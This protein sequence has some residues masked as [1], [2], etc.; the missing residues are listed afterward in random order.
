[1][2]EQ[3]N[4]SLK[5]ITKE[6][7]EETP[8]QRIIQKYDLKAIKN[9]KPLKLTEVRSG[10]LSGLLNRI[11]KNGLPLVILRKK[12]SSEPHTVHIKKGEDA[13]KTKKVKLPIYTA[14]ILTKTDYETLKKTA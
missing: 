6:W 1:M 3:K 14:I 5:E 9:G 2:T 4:I 8:K 13:G 7:L 12:T 11:K 10:Q